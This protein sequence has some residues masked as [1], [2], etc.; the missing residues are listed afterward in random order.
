M[1]LDLSPHFTLEEAIITEH[2][3]LNNYPPSHIIQV[4]GYTASC[5]EVVR[6]ILG[7]SGVR[8]NSWYRSPAVNKA[9]GGSKNSSHMRGEA[10]DFICPKFGT[11]YD[12]CKELESH[13][14]DLKFDQLIYEHTWVH[15]SFLIPPALP[16]L[17]VLT[18]IPETKSYVPGVVF[19][20]LRG[21]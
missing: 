16:R 17:E 12:I 20:H 9:V 2:R 19:K 6:G 1:P 14:A 4:M 18:Y 13:R 10:V 5:M 3:D 7:G 21:K 11:P 15:I 8:V